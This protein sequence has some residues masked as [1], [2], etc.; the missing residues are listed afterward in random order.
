MRSLWTMAWMGIVGCG[1]APVGVSDPTH[2]QRVGW[3]HGVVGGVTVDLY[4]PITPA[5]ADGRPL[6]MVLHGCIQTPDDLKNNADFE[7]TAE[8]YGA[9]IALPK[10]PNGGK[11]AGCWNYYGS[12]H[13]RTSGDA[14]ALLGLTTALLGDVTLD[15]APEKVWIAGISSGASMS[16]VMGCLAPEVYAGVGIAAGPTVGTTAFQITQVKSSLTTGSN[17]CRTLAGSHADAFDTQLAGVI[18]GTRDY[19]VAQ[20]YAP[21]NAQ[22]FAGLYAEAGGVP[23][24]DVTAFDAV[25]APG[26]QPKGSGTTFDDELGPRVSLISATDMGHAWPGGTGPGAEI[27]Y[28]ARQG[29]DYAAYLAEFFSTHA[30]RSTPVELPDEPPDEP[31]TTEP[32]PEPEPEEPPAEDPPAEGCWVD[33]VTDDINGH[34]SRYDVY[35]AGYGAA[36]ETY[37]KLLD[38]YGVFGEFTLYASA[39]GDWYLTPENVPGC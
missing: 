18:S 25:T 29:V 11:Y 24:F 9:V 4:A 36:D 30:R 6:L 16:M 32:E 39:D 19:T 10:V 28:V 15:L 21:L 3:S 20:G 13:T 1:P 23:A 22:I 31:P 2:L 14:A 34:L 5:P 33:V 8:A 7:A 17:V 38:L 27:A 35:P 12:S 37:V 26:Y